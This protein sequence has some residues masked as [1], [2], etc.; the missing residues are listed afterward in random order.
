MAFEGLDFCP[1]DYFHEPTNSYLY[2]SFIILKDVI[3]TVLF[4]YH[5]F[6]PLHI[7]KGGSVIPVLTPKT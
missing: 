7:A 6:I 5:Y 2:T 4:N 3:E 1:K